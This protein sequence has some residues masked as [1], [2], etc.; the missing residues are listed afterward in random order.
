MIDNLW[1]SKINLLSRPQCNRPLHQSLRR[2]L[3]IMKLM[4]LNPAYYGLDLEDEVEPVY[5][6]P[7]NDDTLPDLYRLMASP[8]WLP[9]QSK[10]PTIVLNIDNYN[11]I[12][13]LRLQIEE[14]NIEDYT[15]GFERCAGRCDDMHY[16]SRR[17]TGRREMDAWWTR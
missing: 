11:N 10:R 12:T 14:A 13:Y 7:E 3:K 4:S 2:D 8:W 16:W 17:S 5:Q 6:P 1:P 9:D 15:R